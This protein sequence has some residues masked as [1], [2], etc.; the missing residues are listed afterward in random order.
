MLKLLAAAMVTAANTIDSLV[1]EAA[2]RPELA[3]KIIGALT[4]IGK[5]E[6]N[7]DCRVMLTVRVAK[8]LVGLAG[9]VDAKQR[10]P[11]VKFAEAQAGGDN[12]RIAKPVAKL[13]KKL[14]CARWRQ[15]MVTKCGLDQARLPWPMEMLPVYCRELPSCLISQ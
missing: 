5:I 11:M 6:R 14:G 7:D 12:L 13:L 1:N 4:R 9:K 3:G 10:R 2:A 8:Q 15:R